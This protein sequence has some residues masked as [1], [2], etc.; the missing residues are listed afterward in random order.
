VSN[1]DEAFF[2]RQLGVGVSSA[3][4]ILPFILDATKATSIIDVGCGTGT[5][6]SVARELGCPDVIGIDGAWV[7][8]DQLLIPTPLFN[9]VDLLRPGVPS[10]RFELALCLEVAEHLP[11]E[12]AAA[13]VSFLTAAAP[14]VLFSAAVPFQGGTG[15]I[16]E[17]YP[18]YWLRLFR[19]HDFDAVDC[20]RPR[21]W[22]DRDVQ[23]F[24][25]Q[26]MLLLV[27]RQHADYERLAALGTGLPLDLVHPDA[28]PI[29]AQEWIKG[30]GVG[31]VLKILRPM[32]KDAFKRR[33]GGSR[34]A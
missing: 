26:N 10:R 27:H 6:L 16:N 1:Y 28:V 13:L 30:F 3:R 32:L 15:H 23:F 5:W 11:P 25:R 4:R 14:A 21:F 2:R 12:S 20:V 17:Q 24:Y 8:L 19:T 18:S 22:T 31:N 29:L 34:Q 7:P 33:L 9:V